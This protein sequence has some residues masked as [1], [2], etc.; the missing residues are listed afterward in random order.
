MFLAGCAADRALGESSAEADEEASSQSTGDA[1]EP[2]PDVDIATS[3]SEDGA[4][5]GAEMP[6]VRPGYDAPYP[7]CEWNDGDYEPFCPPTTDAHGF[8]NW[9]VEDG[10]SSYCGDP[11]ECNACLCSV[12][13]R[14][15][16]T[17]EE[18]P[19][20]CPM[21]PSGTAAPECFFDQ[22]FCFLT[23]DDGETCPDGMRCVHLLEI[24][25]FVCAWVN[26]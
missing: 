21:P 2:G 3:T 24:E 16:S 12:S 6:D 19:A 23:C 25:R 17:D 22:A 15:E 9:H 7:Y 8:S 1:P 14:D 20:N 4:A 5:D 11:Q 10:T 13:C 26:E 18:D